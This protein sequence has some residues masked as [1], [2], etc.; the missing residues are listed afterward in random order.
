MKAEVRGPEGMC[1]VEI[2]KHDSRY[3]LHFTPRMDGD[4]YLRVFWCD[5]LLPRCPIYCIARG[6]QPVGPVNHEKVILTGHGL[7]EARVR[8]EAE[9]IIDGG[10]AGPG[11]Y[12]YCAMGLS[13]N[14][15]DGLWTIT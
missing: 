7:V 11:G 8:E 12:S 6:E 4:Y 13:I 1:H 2:E 9:F 15:V 14:A 10:E 5:I 3:L